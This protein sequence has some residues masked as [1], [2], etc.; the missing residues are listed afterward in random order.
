MNLPNFNFKKRLAYATLGLALLAG[1][2]L[3]TT[4]IVPVKIAGVESQQK[5]SAFW[6]EAVS[7]L[8]SNFGAIVSLVWTPW[9]LQV[10]M[11]NLSPQETQAVRNQYQSRADGVLFDRCV[12]KVADTYYTGINNWSVKN[13]QRWTVASRVEGG[14]YTNCYQRMPD[15]LGREFIQKRGW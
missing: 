5:A 15:W 8:N 7:I 1:T 2:T 12:N 3:A 13:P 6:G 4:G 14:G 11:T 10:Y 9:N